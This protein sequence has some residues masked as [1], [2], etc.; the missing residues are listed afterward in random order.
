[1]WPFDQM[2]AFGVMG[3]MALLGFLL[4]GGASGGTAAKVFSLILIV[5]LVGLAAVG[6][7]EFG[8]S[9]YLD[10]DCTASATSDLDA[11]SDPGRR[12]SETPSISIRTGR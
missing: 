10:G 5:G 6:A 9:G 2:L 7:T 8:A 4:T 3:L 12:R 11:I 1:M